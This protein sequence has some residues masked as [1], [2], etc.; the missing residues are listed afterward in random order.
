MLVLEWSEHG[1]PPVQG[2][3]KRRGFG[4][5]LIERSLKGAL[6]G[7]AVLEFAPAGL[8]CRIVLPLTGDR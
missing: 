7:D 1:G 6:A 2:P 3:P 4:S 8:V 5:R